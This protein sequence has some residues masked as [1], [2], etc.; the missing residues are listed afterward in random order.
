MSANGDEQT[1]GIGDDG[2]NGNHADGSAAVDRVA[3]LL[4]GGF[5]AQAKRSDELELRVTRL[6]ALMAM[7]DQERRQ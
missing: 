3:E 6:E 2:A 5:R 7:G 1:S 4:A